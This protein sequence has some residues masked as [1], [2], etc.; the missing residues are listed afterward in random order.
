MLIRAPAVG[1]AIIRQYTG[2]YQKGKGKVKGLPKALLAGLK[3][4]A[5]GP[6]PPGRTQGDTP[7]ILPA[8]LR[9]HLH[10]LHLPEAPCGAR[11]H[12]SSQPAQERDTSATCHR[13][14]SRSH[15]AEGSCLER[16][17]VG[18]PGR[19]ALSPKVCIAWRLGSAS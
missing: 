19:A 7:N 12:R 2:Q 14:S 17:E 13:Y 1:S 15:Q 11:L 5:L 16:A 8:C 3:Y 18:S 9:G 6:Q 4:R 10:P